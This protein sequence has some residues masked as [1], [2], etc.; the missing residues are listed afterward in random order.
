MKH[1]IIL[2]LVG[3]VATCQ[4]FSQGI[5]S[6]SKGQKIV[7]VS[8]NG[9]E[10]KMEMMG[11]E[12]EQIINVTTTSE[13]SVADLSN[14]AVKIEMKQTKLKMNMSVMGQD[15]DYDSE[16]PDDSE[17]GKEAGK[18]LNKIST[19]TTDDKGI[20]TGVDMDEA[21]KDMMKAA[22]NS[23]M[24]K[25]QPLSFLLTLPSNAAV[26]TTWNV[27]FGE[28]SVSKTTYNYTIKSIEN[29]AAT[30]S[31]TG[32]V[33]TNTSV[34]ASGVDMISKLNGTITGTA[35][36]NTKTHILKSRTSAVEMKGTMEMSGQSIPME[37][38]T[39][40]EESFN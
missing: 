24:A 15:V 28:D 20:I 22:P 14:K 9:M 26:N 4:S 18:G 7:Q 5:K 2:V 30:L 3:L 40:T 21:I 34:S 27:S 38:K 33:K 8:K 36:V 6:L 12:I 10:M 29:G 25:G 11:Q 17:M 1:K 37:M 16:K 31:F 23:G 19:I 13:L 39:T 35:V 32:T